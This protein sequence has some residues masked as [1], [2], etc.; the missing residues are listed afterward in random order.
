MLTYF[1]MN[2]GFGFAWPMLIGTIVGL[3][4]VCVSLLLR[5]ETHGREFSSEIEVH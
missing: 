4:N 2:Y 5:P 1:A 3:V